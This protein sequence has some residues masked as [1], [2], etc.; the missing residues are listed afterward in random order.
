MEKINVE[1]EQP[2]VPQIKERNAVEQWGNQ[3]PEVKRWL[4]KLQIKDKNAFNLYR[5]CQWCSKEPPELLKLK[6]DRASVEAEKLLDDF[7]AAEIAELTN[8][9]KFQCITAVKS[10]FKH[11]YKDLARASGAMTLEKVKPT[12]KPRKDELRKLWNWCLNPR[13]KALITF[14]NSTAVAKETLSN[15]QWKHL[16]DNWETVELPCI[17]I[18]SELLKGHGVG[19]YK[20]VRQITFL[21]PEAKRDLI[22]YKEWMEQKVGRKLTSED[23]VFLET[24]VPYK[25]MR[26]DRLGTLIYNLSKTTGVPFSWHDARRY[27]ETALEETNIHPNWARKIRGRKVKGE[28]SPYSQPA[29]EQLRTKYAE[30]V[31]LLE[32]TSEKPTVSK[33]AIKDEVLKALEDATLKPIAD[34]YHLTL[35][36]VKTMM[37]QKKM[38]VEELKELLKLRTAT[39]GGCSMHNCQKIV[40]ESDLPQLLS[41]GFHVAAVLPSGKVV[42]EA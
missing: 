26:Y 36:Q 7:V 33:E 5:F 2:K 17:N 20:G 18:P 39:N 28:E 27:V 29:I 24:Y 37:R 10:F 35:E 9:V 15:L 14:V 19:R 32:F 21:T 23:Y 3:Y 8:A 12:H 25:P 4:S 6:D 34:K 11:N 13:D 22:S 30:A 41:E 31:P 1:P 42:V 40:S 38:D 16:E